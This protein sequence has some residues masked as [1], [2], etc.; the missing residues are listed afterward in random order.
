MQ[1]LRTV[2]SSDTII[3]GDGAIGTMLQ[4]RGLVAGTM[5]EAWNSE[6]PED[7]LAVHRAYLE[8]GAN[9]LTTNTFGAN[10]IRMREG[11]LGSDV[12]G[13]VERA[14]ALARQVAEG[15]AWVAGSVGPTGRLMQ[16]L[17]DLSL[18]EAEDVYAEQIEALIAAGVDLIVVETHHDVEEAGAAVRMARQLGNLPVFASFAFNPR[19]RTMMGLKAA[20]AA[21]AMEALGVSAVGANC[22]DGP[23][24]VAKALEQMHGA[25]DLPLLARSNAG[26]PQLGKDAVTLW[27]IEAAAMAQHAQ[28]FVSL[29]A[30]IVGGCCGTG[31]SHVA[32]IRA[33]LL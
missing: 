13:T 9:Y 28:R 19:G 8:A 27:D 12:A 1:D 31:P 15:Q 16:P 30:R 4:S 2:L 5:P 21:V 24:A 23:E 33:A 10:R 25:T 14:V 20:D 18:A 32:A 22:G 26:I 7:M 29:G 6:R 11:G 3:I 17:G